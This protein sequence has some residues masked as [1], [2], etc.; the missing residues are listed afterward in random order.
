M[1]SIITNNFAKTNSFFLNK[2]VTREKR[3]TSK[4]DKVSTKRHKRKHNSTSNILSC[5]EYVVKSAL[6]LKKAAS[7][8]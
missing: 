7:S 8:I 5:V 3:N 6:F 4:E 2:K 1:F